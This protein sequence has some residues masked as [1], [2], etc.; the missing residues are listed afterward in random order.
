[1][2][3]IKEIQKRKTLGIF[4]NSIEIKAYDEVKKKMVS[5]I[6]TSFAS[7][8]IAYKR[9]KMVWKAYL[10]ANNLISTV[11]RNSLGN[12]TVGENNQNQ[13]QVNNLSKQSNSV[14]FISDSDSQSSE[15]E[16][17]DNL[18]LTASN[19]NRSTNLSEFNQSVDNDAIGLSSSKDEIY[20]PPVDA[21][22][23]F[24][25]CKIELKMPLGQIYEKFLKDGAEYSWD[26]FYQEAVGNTNVSITEWKEIEPNISIRDLNFLI[27]VK[28]VPFVTQTRVHK[29]QKLK[30]D[31]DKYTLSGSST[32]LDIPY[33][34][35]FHI[36][37]TWEFVPNGD[38]CVLRTTA[39]VNFTKS[40]M[41]KFKIEK[42][43]REEFKKE[44]D[45]WCEYITTKNILYENFNPTGRKKSVK[46]EEI[47][48]HGVE[49]SETKCNVNLV[50]KFS[51]KYFMSL[52][53]KIKNDILSFYSSHPRDFI[54]FLLL[55]F[56][57]V[58]LFVLFFN[59]LSINQK[60]ILQ[61]QQIEEL[62]KIIL[63]NHRINGSIN[64]SIYEDKIKIDL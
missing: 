13:S 24:E 64:S 54:N 50:K 62:K 4:N 33:S 16:H 63:S 2:K 46:D 35:Y 15:D 10:R 32:S 42:K 26:K 58:M 61:N 48:T 47:L 51:L 17:N 7:R 56:I 27:K 39:F 55:I 34:S 41:F 30:K 8:N 59:L 25:C 9:I 3:D 22:K 14:P 29:A 6:F 28:D 38:R 60:V 31:G 18:N 11:K 57:S 43:T 45:K 44:V 37:D 19:F 36:E 5:L 21:E 52:S 1:L 23:V 12:E 40:T 53:F 20:F 49:K